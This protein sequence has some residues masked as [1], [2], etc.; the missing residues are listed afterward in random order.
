MQEQPITGELENAEAQRAVLNLTLAR[1]PM[2][3]LSTEAIEARL[4]RDDDVEG[5]VRTLL[6]VGLLEGNDAGVRPTY[7]AVHFEMLE[8]QWAIQSRIR[9]G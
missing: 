9:R 4:D 5:A 2:P 7:P 6:T 3:D 1:F 8:M